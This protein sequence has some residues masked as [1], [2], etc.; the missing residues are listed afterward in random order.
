[1]RHF[2]SS[3]EWQLSTSLHHKH[4]RCHVLVGMEKPSVKQWEMYYSRELMKQHV[5]NAQFFSLSCES[6]AYISVDQRKGCL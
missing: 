5:T 3:S 4:Q 6:A 2:C 1:M